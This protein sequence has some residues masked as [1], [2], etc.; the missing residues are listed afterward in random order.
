MEKVSLHQ[1]KDKLF[2]LG[3][4]P[5]FRTELSEVYSLLPHQEFVLVHLIP[6]LLASRSLPI[7]INRLYVSHL[8]K[9]RERS[10]L[11]TYIPPLPIYCYGPL[12][13]K[14]TQSACNAFSPF[15]NPK[16]LFNSPQI[17]LFP[18]LHQN[19]LCI[20]NDLCVAN[21]RFSSNRTPSAA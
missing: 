11:V 14:T 6:S 12:E 4:H 10:L 2:I 3:P 15:L 9:E 21:V 13:H 1:F 17:V 19:C 7:T 5:L 8:R 16:L 18:P 20:T